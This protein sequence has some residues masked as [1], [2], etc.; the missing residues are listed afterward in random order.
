MLKL[1]AMVNSLPNSPIRKIFNKAIKHPDW[2]KFTV[3]EP[4]FTT[5]KSIIDAAYKAAIDGN[6]HYVHNAGIIE[7]RKEI[8]KK[9]ENENGI[10]VNPETEII[11]TNGGTDALFLAMQTLLEP[12]DEVIIPDPG[13]PVYELQCRLCSAK[14]VFVPVYADDGFMYNQ[15]RII[16]ALTNKTKL[17][18][19]NTPSNP[20]GGIV[21]EN[22]CNFLAQIAKERD[23][24]IISDEVYE[25]II[26]DN[27][28][29]ISICS[30]PGMKNRTITVNSFSK[31]YAMSG[32]RIGY[33]VACEEIIKNMVKLHELEASC[34]NVPAQFAAIHALRYSQGDVAKMLDQFN[35]RREIMVKN[36][37]S[38]KGIQCNYPKGTFYA[39]A[40]IADSHLSSEEFCNELMDGY[41]V[42]AIP[43]TAFG[44]CGEGYIRLS[45]AVSEQDI[46]EGLNRIESFIRKKMKS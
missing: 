14:P 28:R 19:L 29:H 39:F 40:R 22:I 32:W 23:L 43:G 6:T 18:I 33:A 41:G 1:N 42:V 26:Y 46:L 3:G 10:L 34:T 12:G 20:T 31:S 38:I 4:D 35:K 2:V 44:K 37:N 7:L 8:C 9:L 30:L 21:D 13:F 15:D 25:K 24:Y 27:H 45:F 17:I 11:V 5:P 36:L 16:K